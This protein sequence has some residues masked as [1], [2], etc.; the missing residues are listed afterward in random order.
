[1]VRGEEKEQ[2]M[3]MMQSIGTV[4]SDRVMAALISG[5]EVEFGRGAER[6]WRIVSWR[7]RRSI[8]TGM[9]AFRS[10]G[11]EHMRCIG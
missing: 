6:R 7:P 9:R 4:A 1:M 3:S 5:L 10:A 2:V 11:S 8:S